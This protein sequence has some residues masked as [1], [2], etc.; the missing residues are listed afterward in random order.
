MNEPTRQCLCPK[1]LSEKNLVTYNFKIVGQIQIY[2]C[3]TCLEQEPFSKY[4]LKVGDK[5]GN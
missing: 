1:P 4:I 5:I 3:D 2:V